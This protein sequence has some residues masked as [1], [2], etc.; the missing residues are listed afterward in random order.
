M[1]MLAPGSEGRS[2]AKCGV[3]LRAAI[4]GL[5]SL[6]AMSAS[7]AGA[8]MMTTCDQL[9]HFEGADVTTIVLE[10]AYAGKPHQRLS[11]AAQRLSLLI[12]QDALLSQ[13]KYRKIG[14]AFVQVQPMGPDKCSPKSVAERML[15]SMP[16]GKGLIVLSGQLYEQEQQLYLQSSLLFLRADAAETLE[17]PAPEKIRFVA[18]LPSQTLVFAPR[19][20]S[21]ND[22]GR[23]DAEFAAGMRVHTEPNEASTSSTLEHGPD[24]PFAYTVVDA[25]GSW[26][27]IEPL[28]DYPG[29]S[30]WINFGNEA[31]HSE[32]HE[33]M[34]ELAFLDAA[35][36][37]LEYRISAATR[38]AK[39]GQLVEWLQ[40]ALE[41]F[42][43]ASRKQGAGTDDGIALGMGAG[44]LGVIRTQQDGWKAAA[45]TKPFA[46]MVTAMPFS[47]DARNLDVLPKLY[48]CCLSGE[49]QAGQNSAGAQAVE[50]ALLNALS[51]EPGNKQVI[52]NLINFYRLLTLRPNLRWSGMS[53]VEV[54]KRL[55]AVTTVQQ[56]LQ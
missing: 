27:K 2:C 22:I 48:A 10:Y 45:A 16:T 49:D 43:G 20:L 23:I 24:L 4:V 36:A 15:Q 25:K 31:A 52:A 6:I 38:E 13:L 26:M 29:P 37:Y 53:G 21:W 11:Q 28:R 12:Q 1:Q 8:G 30:G 7:P 3:A 46:P 33:K 50:A 9:P 56:S 5:A 51:V 54:E 47:A 17:P 55:G 19:R 40:S 34:P 42:D 35:V 44:M 18:A 39:D 32:L 41:R 14:V